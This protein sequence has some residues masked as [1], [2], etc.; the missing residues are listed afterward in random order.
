M[1]VGQ[2]P[3]GVA[4]G[5]TSAV[6]DNLDAHVVLDLDRHRKFGRASMPDNVADRLA[7]DGF[8]VI[9]QCSIDNR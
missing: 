2:A 7:H 6:V 9:G 4:V 8:G 1:Q 3:A 5:D